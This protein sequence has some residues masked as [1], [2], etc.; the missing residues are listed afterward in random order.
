[1]ADGRLGQLPRVLVLQAMAAVRR[2]DWNVA[3][4]AIDEA[5]RPASDLGGGCRCDCGAGSGHAR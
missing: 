4:P 2:A 5:R 1:M 3:L